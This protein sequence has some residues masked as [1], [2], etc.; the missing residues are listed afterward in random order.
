[1][2]AAAA[3]PISTAVKV[4]VADI[5]INA[6]QELSTLARR[7]DDITTDFAKKVEIESN[8]NNVMDDVIQQVRKKPGLEEASKSDVYKAAREAAVKN[9]LSPNS[10]SVKHIDTLIRFSELEDSAIA[11]AKPGIDAVTD[12]SVKNLLENL[13]RFENKITDVASIGK[14][15]SEDLDNLLTS[16]KSAKAA[17]PTNVKLY[18]AMEKLVKN[19][20]LSNVQIALKFLR[21][22]PGS[23]V[24]AAGTVTA[25]TFLGLALDRY[26]KSKDNPRTITKVERDGFG[27]KKLRISYTPNIK[28]LK[29]DSITIR[30]SMTTPSIDGSPSVL[31]SPNDSSVIIEVS[32][33][34]KT[35]APGGTIDVTPNFTA[36]L[37][38]EIGEPVK[39]IAEGGGEIIGAGLGGAGEGI[40]AF[41]SGL[42]GDGTGTMSMLVLAVIVVLMVIK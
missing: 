30:G 18:D 42:F 17:D 13:T 36:S 32:E 7:Y 8:L 34:M 27:S 14:L 15:S 28:I 38:K 33:S 3:K 19:G 41:F 11:A 9:G 26:L 4:A 2:A 6:L 31:S 40:G 22:N 37:G 24:I 20:E 25:V 35:L 29:Q 12:L 1:M 23:F 10:R 16:L 39:A 21:D 5:P